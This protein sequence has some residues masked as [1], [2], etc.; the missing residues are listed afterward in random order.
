MSDYYSCAEALSNIEGF[1]LTGVIYYIDDAPAGFVLGEKITHDTYALHFAKG[2][3]DY[4]GLYQFMYNH[5]AKTLHGSC[6]WINFEQD[7]GIAALRQAKES[8]QPDAMGHKYRVK[9][10]G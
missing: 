8:Y 6:S 4:K 2:I 7:L 3:T 1:L 9:L 5:F 10:K